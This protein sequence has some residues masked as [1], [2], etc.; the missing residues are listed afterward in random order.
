PPLLVR[1]ANSLLKHKV[2]FGSDYPLIT[3]DRWL[4]DFAALDI[5]PEVR[6]LILKQNAAKLLGLGGG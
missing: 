4:S 1:Y 6:P 3:P 2:L 5:K